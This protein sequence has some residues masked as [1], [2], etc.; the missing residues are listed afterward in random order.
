MSSMKIKPAPPAVATQ[1]LSNSEQSREE[2]DPPNAAEVPVEDAEDYA[3][4]FNLDRATALGI[5]IP[6]PLLTALNVFGSPSLKIKP[7][8][9]GR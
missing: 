9:T 2:D 4:V 3:I 1:T 5:D 6:K 8:I 7:E